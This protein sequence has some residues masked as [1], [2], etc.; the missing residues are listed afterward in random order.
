MSQVGAQGPYPNV[1]V[2]PLRG[3]FSLSFLGFIEDS[4]EFVMLIM[5]ELAILVNILLISKLATRHTM[6]HIKSLTMTHAH[7]DFVSI[8]HGKRKGT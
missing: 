6:H 1:K 7:A 2:I 3:F 4:H 8:F 5:K